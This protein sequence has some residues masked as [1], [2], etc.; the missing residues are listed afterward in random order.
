[1]LQLNDSQQ[2]AVQADDGPQL[3]LAGAGSG[4]TRTII[5]RI[6]HLISQRQVPPHRILTV[7]FTN[8]AAAELR[9]RLAELIG[10]DG[11][12]VVSGTFHA[13]SL[14]FLRRYAD[15]LGYPRSFQ[16]IDADDQKTLARRLLKARNIDKDKLSP[17]Y[18][19]S[20]IENCKH[21]GMTP[22]E[23]PSEIW[24]GVDM[25]D[26]YVAYQQELM[27]L[28]RMDFSDLIL[29]CVRLLREHDE[30]SAALRDRFTHVLVDE[31]QDTNPVQSQWLTL[32]CQD[33][34]NL[35]VVGDDDQSIYGWRGADVRHILDFERIWQGAGVYRL[36]ENYRSTAAILELAN[37]II[38]DN[39]DRHEKRL[40]ATRHAG[41][42]P[43][44][45]VCNDEYDEARRIA[46]CL[47]HRNALGVPWSDMAVLYRSNRQS[48]P[49]EQVLGEA[50]M[51]YRVIGGVGFFERME[52]KD[53]LAYWALLHRCA[54]AIQLLRICNK[55]KRGIGGKGEETLIRQLAKSGLRAADWLDTLAKDG[56][57]GPAA[58]LAPLAR[59][60]ASLRPD[61]LSRPDLGLGDLIEETGYVAALQAHGQLEAESRMENIRA[62]QNFIEISMAEGL[63]PVD[64]MDRA[65][66]LQS[67]EE[68]HEGEAI[69]LMSLHRAKGL[70]FD[71]VVVSGVEDGLLPHQRAIDEGESGLAEERRLLYVGVTRA[72]EYLLITSARVRRVFGDMHFP[73]PSRFVAR[74]AED[75][76]LR[77]EPVPVSQNPQAQEG[78]QAGVAVR[79]PTFGEGVVTACEGFGDSSRVTVHFAR[80]GTKRLML[81]Y[82]ALEPV[83]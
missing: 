8:K 9:S 37:A 16:V 33:H 61:S 35:T 32:L 24:S 27:R 56:G 67:G 14:R 59:T 79:H 7:T 3:I 69:S 34:R 11:G 68:R 80:A 36:E 2:Q 45:H 52:I 77:D 15:R 18:L 28:E 74:L 12:G 20:W 6:G 13:I 17:G 62:L 1:M 21:V 55:P 76:L 39:S 42:T 72:K 46:S 82:A 38:V 53:A 57:K 63:T 29:N 54:D 22:A 58:R 48:L 83:G 81:K 64:F 40:A 41:R 78:I 10:D 71:S 25:R 73:L 65:A 31:Y 66:L 75:V 44:W 51:P 50:G 4:K 47:K 5:H 49:I 23:A 70:E 43:K 30:V 60:I 19:L 26:L